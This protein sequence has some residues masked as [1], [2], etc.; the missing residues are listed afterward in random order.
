[1]TR[2]P[3]PVTSAVAVRSRGGRPAVRAPC[4]SGRERDRSNSER[5]AAL[6]EFDKVWQEFQDV[7]GFR[8]RVS[9][10]SEISISVISI[11]SVISEM[12]ISVISIISVMT[13]ISISVISTIPVI[14]IPINIYL[15]ICV[16]L[17]P[18]PPVSTP[19]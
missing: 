10:I 4:A 7:V 3:C 19:C 16:Y 15:Y 1:M 9:I 11:I 6:C 14:S 13:E 17:R 5:L 18:G 2:H 8:F 12:T